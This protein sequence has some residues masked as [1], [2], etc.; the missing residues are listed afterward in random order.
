[1]SVEF[2]VFFSYSREDQRYVDLVREQLDAHHVS[3]W[4]DRRDIP[5]GTPDWTDAIRKAIR[6]SRVCVVIASP[7]F[8]ESQ[9][10]QDELAI[11]KMH[12]RAIIPLWVDGEEWLECVPLGYGRIQ[13]IDAHAQQFHQAITT[14]LQN[15]QRWSETDEVPRSTPTGSLKELVANDKPIPP[16]AD[17]KPEPSVANG[18]ASLTSPPPSPPNLVANQAPSETPTLIVL[19]PT[20]STAHPVIAT[21]YEPRNPYKGLRSFELQDAGDFFGRSAL[22]E[23]LVNAVRECLAQYISTARLLAVVGPSG[24]GKSS[25][26]MAGLLPLLQRGN[27]GGGILGGSDQWA[28]VDPVVPGSSPINNLAL[29]IQR[30]LPTAN[31]NEIRNE[32]IDP[33]GRGFARLLH[34]FAQRP[35]QRVVFVIDQFEEIFT[36]TSSQQER[37]QWIDF[38]VFAA[39]DSRSNALVIL[40]FRSD[41]YGQLGSVPPL[42]QLIESH[43][44]IVPAMNVEDLREIIEKPAELPDTQLVFDDDLVGDLL[45]EIQGEEGALPL[46]EFTLARLYEQRSGHRLTREAYPTD[47]NSVERTMIM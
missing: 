24:S 45:F 28:Y 6:S 14:L 34:R 35:G 29:A 12:K 21:P 31:I 5:A 26:V 7:H 20:P 23:E 41:F 39:T 32:L 13:Y 8:V 40:T 15:I 37:R 9:F 44:K 33:S 16:L 25:V 10:A 47:L 1:M 38:L 36:Q 22:I 46:L 19:R 3:Y 17:T 42:A 18:G 4:V 11:A 43:Q 30:N 2:A 27:L